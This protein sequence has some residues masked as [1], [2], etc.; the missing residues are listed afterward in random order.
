MFF[1]TRKNDVLLPLRYM[2]SMHSVSAPVRIDLAGGWT[3]VGPYPHDIGGEVINF[4][5]DKRVTVSR[6]SQ[7]NSDDLEIKFDVPR[8]SGLGTSSAMNVAINAINN[9][10]LEPHYLAQKAFEDEIISGNICGKQDHWAS[11]HGG[12]QHLLFIGDSVEIL[13]FEPMKSSLNW[14]RKHLIIS[15]SGI[16]R[17]SGKIQEMVWKKYAKGDENVINGLLK[18]RSA[19]KMMANGLQADRRDLIVKSL[20]EV[21][22]GV[23][24]ISSDIQGPFKPVTNFL[25]ENNKIVAWKA[26]GAGGGGCT[27]LLCA[28]YCR[29]DVISHINHNGWK[30]IDWNYDDSGIIIHK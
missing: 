30:L 4:T 21:S 10:N 6:V 26:L 12:F 7:N 17:N 15:Y 23:D 22:S 2:F 8:G 18:I 9:P 3:D 20:R 25:V 5:I 19:T 13:P 28:P 11:A 29:E 1:G 27:A 14:L 16:T 24:E